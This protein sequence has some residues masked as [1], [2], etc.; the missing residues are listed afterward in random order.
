MIPKKKIKHRV[1][2]SAALL[3]MGA[4]MTPIIV[5]GVAVAW[6]TIYHYLA[7]RELVMGR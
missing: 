6:V 5:G 4:V 7:A 2:D 3:M 1:A